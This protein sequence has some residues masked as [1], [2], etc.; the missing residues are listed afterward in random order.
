MM[1]VGIAAVEL[2]LSTVEEAA[3][4]LRTT[5][6]QESFSVA[7]RHL[8]RPITPVALW[9]ESQTFRTIKYIA[10]TVHAVHELTTVLIIA[11]LEIAILMRT[12]WRRGRRF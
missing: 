8:I 2:N 4:H 7:V 6:A 11:D 10:P 12:F 3:F 5:E 1:A 9:I